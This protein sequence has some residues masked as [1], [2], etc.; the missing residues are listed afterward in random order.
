MLSARSISIALIAALFLLAVPGGAAPSLKQLTVSPKN[1]RALDHLTNYP[2]LEVL[3]ISC[4]ENLKALP[5]SIGKL[6]KLRELIMDN[7][8]GCS[9]NPVLPESIG[10]LQSLEKLVLNGAQDPRGPGDQPKQR[11]PLPQSMSRLQNLTYLDLGRNGLEEIPAFVKD[12]PKLKELRFAWNMKLKNVPQFIS[13][14]QELTTLD[15]ESDGLSDLPDFLSTMPKLSRIALG[16]NCRI[17]ASASKKNDLR[18]RF[19][20]VTFDFRNEYDCPAK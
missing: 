10:N 5:D 19:P 11:H 1:A 14:L 6:T 4:L 7:G 17:T 9:M 20:K 8:N 3:S 13:N 12:L 15:L 16:G 2:D 18:H